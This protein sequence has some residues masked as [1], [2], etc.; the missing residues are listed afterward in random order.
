M[1]LAILA[2]QG[3]DSDA[4]ARLAYDAGIAAVLPEQRPAFRSVTD[5]PRQLGVS[6]TRLAALRP[7]A[8]QV[9]IEGLVRCVAHDKKLSVEESELL[10]TVCAVLH[11]PLP[12]IVGQAA[13]TANE[14]AGS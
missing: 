12:P 8:K 14:V 6:L 3:S 4:Q 1:T 2:E 9:F 13:T 10:R 5:W 11:C 7:F